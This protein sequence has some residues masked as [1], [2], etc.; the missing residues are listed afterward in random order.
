[1]VLTVQSPN[2]LSVH[3]DLEDFVAHPSIVKRCFFIILYF[4]AHHL[5]HLC[6]V[7]DVIPRV[8]DPAFAADAGLVQCVTI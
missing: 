2:M 1:M 7:S 6:S 8:E 5:H 3:K 4:T